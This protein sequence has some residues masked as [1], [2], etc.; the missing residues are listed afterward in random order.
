MHGQRINGDNFTAA[1]AGLAKGMPATDAQAFLG[2]PVNVEEYQHTLLTWVRQYVDEQFECLRQS[3]ATL[4][5]TLDGNQRRTAAIHAGV[6]QNV[7]EQTE[8]LC[9]IQYGT[10]VARLSQLVAEE[11]FAPVPPAPEVITESALDAKLDA[12][13]TAMETRFTN[14]LSDVLSKLPIGAAPVPLE[15]PQS[16]VDHVNEAPESTNAEPAEETDHAPRPA[17]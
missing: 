4:L 13:T 10:D 15:S 11:L 1:L 16:D 2:A 8:L 14:L 3:M 7:M 5:Q 17:A 9:D 6:I 12:L